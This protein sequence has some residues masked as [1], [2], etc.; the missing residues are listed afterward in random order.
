MHVERV[1][2][3]AGVCCILVL[4]TNSWYKL[5]F[6]LNL[7]IPYTEYST[8][9]TRYRNVP[10][11]GI[12]LLHWYEYMPTHTMPVSEEHS[13]PVPQTQVGGEPCGLEPSWGSQAGAVAV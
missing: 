2:A 6:N 11:Y 3:T 1:A 7:H 13:F 5:Y 4:C 8:Y 12:A 10:G 9:H